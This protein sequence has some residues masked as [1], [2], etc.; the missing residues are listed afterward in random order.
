MSFDGWV[1]GR[2]LTLT[3]EG[4]D[5]KLDQRSLAHATLAEQPYLQAGQNTVFSL[6]LEPIEYL[7]LCYEPGCKGPFITFSTEPPP[8]A[9]IPPVIACQLV[10]PPHHP[11]PPCPPK[12]I[13]LPPCPAAPPLP[14]YPI[15]QSPPPPPPLPSPPPPTYMWPHPPALPW[16]PP[17]IEIMPKQLPHD[18]RR[19]RNY[20]RMLVLVAI[21]SCWYGICLFLLRVRRR[22]ALDEKL[23]TAE[24]V[25]R[26]TNTRS[27]STCERENLQRS[28][29]SW[30]VQVDLGDEELT[31]SVPKKSI[32]GVRALKRAIADAATTVRRSRV[33][34]KW[35][36]TKRG[37]SIAMQIQYLDCEDELQPLCSS[38]PFKDILKSTRLHVM[39][40]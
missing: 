19:P 40:T 13:M 37:Q 26:T 1:D 38:T 8:D 31:V 34:P 27:V 15:P 10:E 9:E 24:D 2:A 14:L 23:P 36:H 20:T 25:E 7:H 30:L 29:V 32:R 35:M 18:E 28:S 6:V 39:P 22:A 16:P 4:Q 12:P 5:L 11:P 17:S 33:P 21:L 3:F